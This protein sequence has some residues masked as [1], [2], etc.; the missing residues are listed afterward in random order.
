[1]EKIVEYINFE[2]SNKFTLI[3]NHTTSRPVTRGNSASSKS[4]SPSF[5][6]ISGTKVANPNLANNY[7]NKS[8]SSN[9]QIILS[10]RRSSRC[11]SNLKDG[12]DLEKSINLNDS[13]IIDAAT[14]NTNNELYEQ[15]LNKVDLI[16]RCLR[17]MH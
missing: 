3:F 7:D 15:V 9:R 8:Q 13:F 4:H 17:C 1:M 16:N 12:N 11:F 10:E 14:N 6:K 5:R 2:S